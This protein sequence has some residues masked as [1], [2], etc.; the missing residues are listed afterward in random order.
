MTH[1]AFEFYA[2][3]ATLAAIVVLVA[4]GVAAACLGHNTEAIGVGAAVTG[5]IGVIRMPRGTLPGQV[6]PTQTREGAQ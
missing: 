6:E 5:L 3:L 1:N 4:I 2:F